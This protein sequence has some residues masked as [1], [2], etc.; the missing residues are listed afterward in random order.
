[1]STIGLRRARI[2]TRIEID[3]YLEVACGGVVVRAKY[4]PCSHAARRAKVA[5][6]SDPIPEPGRRIICGVVAYIFIP[7]LG[8]W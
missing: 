6:V 4:V 2:E 8:D 7:G 5:L 1:M 3:T